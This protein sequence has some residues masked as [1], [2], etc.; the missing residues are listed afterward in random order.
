MTLYCVSGARLACH[1]IS[2]CRCC[3]TQLRT[4]AWQGGEWK[5]SHYI[6]EWQEDKPHGTGT[7]TTRSGWRYEGKLRQG[8][9]HGR[10][11]LT[12]P[13]HLFC[14]E[15]EWQNDKAHGRGRV[16]FREDTSFATCCY[17]GE[18]RGGKRDGHGKLLFYDFYYEGEFREGLPHG[19]GKLTLADGS[20]FHEGQWCRGKATRVCL[21]CGG[22]CVATHAVPSCHLSPRRARCASVVGL[23]RAGGGGGAS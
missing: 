6:G 14:Y 21:H 22:A 17:E 15:G 20:I 8:L 13:G 10:G 7:R 9:F 2:L 19:H 23:A 16:V 12:G 3:L 18:W 4:H 1:R 11:K 5:G